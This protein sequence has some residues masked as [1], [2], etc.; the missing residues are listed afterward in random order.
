MSFPTHE[1]G[2]MNFNGLDWAIAGTVIF[3]IYRGYISG[4]VQQIFGFFGTIFALI[5]AFHF[6]NDLGYVF[7][8]AEY[9]RK[10][11]NIIS[12]ILIAVGVSGIMGFGHE[13]AGTYGDFYD[14]S[15]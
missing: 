1:E 5:M 2:K 11:C 3:C 6:Y 4:F 12:F 8:M 7:R 15:G 10:P 9:L 14:F 13:V